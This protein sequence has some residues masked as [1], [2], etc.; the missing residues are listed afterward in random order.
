MAA[1]AT[2]VLAAA[3]T[4]VLAAAATALATT[5]TTWTRVLA[6]TVRRPR[7]L[8]EDQVFWSDLQGRWVGSCGSCLRIWRRGRFFR[9]LGVWCGIWDSD[10]LRCRG[11]RGRQAGW[12]LDAGPQRTLG[13][14]GCMPLLASHAEMFAPT[15]VTAPGGVVRV[16]LE[17]KVG[18]IL[19]RLQLN[20][21]EGGEDGQVRGE[22]QFVM[23]G[24][25]KAL[26]QGIAA[27]GR[28]S[29]HTASMLVN[30]LWSRAAGTPTTRTDSR[31]SP[32]VQP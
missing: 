28:P 3:A 25:I 17:D 16:N 21:D 9:Y 20:R 19:L 5:S 13:G 4:T 15:A 27:R 32:G 26:E 24:A 18:A 12:D 8:C 22:A 2:P 10:E 7:R 11:H 1:V 23:E 6:T 30:M 31:A 14:N 29:G